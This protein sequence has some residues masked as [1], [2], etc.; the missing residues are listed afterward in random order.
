MRSSRP[1]F[2][3]SISR[4]VVERRAYRVRS[5]VSLA[6]LDLLRQSVEEMGCEI[7][8][9]ANA[10][11]VW[12]VGPSEVLDEA[13]S[14]SLAAVWLSTPEQVAIEMLRRAGWEA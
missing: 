10:H 4:A 11:T 6:S 12:L 5:F 7:E 8:V 9:D 1:S 14:G 2:G 13:E 3:P